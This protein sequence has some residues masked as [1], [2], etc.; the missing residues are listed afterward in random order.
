M[1]K[2]N[3]T[4]QTRKDLALKF[5]QFGEGN[6]LRAF[7]DWMIQI[8]NDSTNLN[9][10]GVIIQPLAN[11]MVDRLKEQDN[12]YHVIL[13]GIKEGKPIREIQRIDCILDSVNPYD[14]YEKYKAYF[15]LPEL[16]FVFSN[17]TEA[18]ITK[19]ENEDI[20]AAPPA[21]FPGKV[22]ALLYQRYKKFKGA[23]DKGLIFVC[24]EL[25]ENNATRLKSIILEL[26]E[27]NNLEPEFKIW[28]NQACT[29]CNSLVDRIVT[30][31]PK[32]KIADVQ[33]E[34]GF[35][36]NMIV[37]AEY[38]HLWA[39]EGSDKEKARLPLHNAGLNVLWM[40]NLKTFRDKKVRVLNG[41]HTALVPV[42]L[43][44]GYL[45]VKEAFTNKTIETYIRN[46]ISKEVLPNIAGDTDSLE[47]FALEILD[48]FLNPYLKH[49][50]K[51][52]SLNSLS[53]WITRDYP[54]LK[55]SIERTGKLPKRLCFSLAALILLYNDNMVEG[56][57]V[58]DTNT[59]LS[60][61]QA[62]W[63]S[64]AS[65]SEKVNNILSNHAL[66]DINLNQHDGLTQKVS[67]YIKQIKEV[68]IL[69]ALMT[70]EK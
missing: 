59:E 1:K 9:M 20:N 22:V 53:K 52:I 61:M 2:I 34:L 33:Q 30:G 68:G 51:D 24:C 12:L 46:L 10:G 55:N 29:F 16:E 11:G 44:A 58:N 36:D 66:W 63:K 49:F 6:F 64:E 57:K 48:R 19:V 65:L 45:T 62:E 23:T 39:I 21:S 7:V 69:S 15:L 4:T 27:E 54:S 28:I 70:L 14:E 47:Q 32:D 67:N 43:L 13:E 18:G 38:F 8:G 25:I 35:E 3:N 42:G 40:D 17:T 56:F 26:A 50:M 31:F 60:A 5:L 37:T 41:A